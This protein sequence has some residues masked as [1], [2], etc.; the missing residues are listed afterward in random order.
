MLSLLIHDRVLVNVIEYHRICPN[1]IYSNTSLTY[2]Q[3]NKNILE[4]VLNCCIKVCLNSGGVD[5]SKPVYVYKF[6]K[7]S[8]IHQAFL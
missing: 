6:I 8:N 7:A 3:I 1:K 5:L 2:R 4:F